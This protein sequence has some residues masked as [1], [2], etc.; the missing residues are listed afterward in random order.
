VLNGTATFVSHYEPERMLRV[1]FN[2]NPPHMA[3]E[4]QLLNDMQNPASPHFHQFLSTEVWTDQFGPSE[5]DEQAVVEWA[6]S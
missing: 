5:E 1:T 4:Q 2:L 6:E 3:E